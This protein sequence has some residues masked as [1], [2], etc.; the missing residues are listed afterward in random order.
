MQ[1]LIIVGAGGLGREVF[2]WASHHPDC[3]K[4]WSIAGFIDD[5][6]NALDNFRYPVKV[7]NSISNYIP[8]ADDVLV[9][10][11]GD[12]AIKRLVCERLIAHSAKFISLIHPTV[13]MGMNVNLAK[14]VVICPHVT[15]TADIQVGTFSL[16]NCHS[17]A[18][19]DV[20]I[21]AWS[22]ISGHCD[23]TGGCKIGEGAFLASG[24]RLLP[25]KTVGSNAYV[26]A[27]SV[28]IKSVQSEDR[29]FGNPAR[30]II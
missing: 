19:H 22:T 27:A 21:G 9:C 4:V 24:V 14:G 23:V 26:G 15:L 13:V 7:I 16:I 20:D 11:I 18:G 8:S 30:S 25:G 1:R 5:N 6:P 17:S 28:V 10:G 2:S 3:G 29:V 12:P